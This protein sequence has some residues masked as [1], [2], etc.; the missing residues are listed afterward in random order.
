MTKHSKDLPHSSSIQKCEYDEATKDMHI[1]FAA[2][3]RHCFK[4][5]DKE[6]YDGIC[7]HESPGKYFHMHIRKKHQSVKAD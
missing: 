4:D 2:G 1:T 5:V 7:A 3:G 6:H